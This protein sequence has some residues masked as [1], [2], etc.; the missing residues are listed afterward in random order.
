MKISAIVVAAGRSSRF[1]GGN[2]LLAK[3]DG[4]QIIRHVINQINTSRVDQIILVTPPD[5]ADLVA[6]AGSGRWQWIVNGQAETGLASSI[7]AGLANVST[8]SDGT[9]IVLADMPLVRTALIDQLC[10]AFTTTGGQK[11]VFPQSLDGRQG[12]PVLWPRSLFADLIALTGDRGG[13]S[14]LAGHP[15]LHLPVQVDDPS[16]FL[17]I[18]TTSDLSAIARTDR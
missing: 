13:K 10:D 2:K 7:A 1:E 12:N 8:A 6:A 16:A 3:L 9:L 15:G 4:T 14:I 11:I 18:D 5:G 17:D